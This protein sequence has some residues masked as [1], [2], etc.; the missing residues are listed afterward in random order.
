[1]RKALARVFLAFD[2]CYRLIHRLQP[3]NEFLFINRAVYRGPRREFA[4][5]TTLQPGDPIGIIHFNNRYMSRVQARS[6]NSQSSKRAAFAF[7]AA[8]IRSMQALARQVNQ[9]PALGDLKVISGV[10]W[11]KAHG[12]QLGFEIEPLPPGRRQRFLRA[13]FRLLLTLLFPHLA[14]RENHRLQPHQFWMTRRQLQK[15]TVIEDKH[16]AQRLVKYGEPTV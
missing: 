15:L 14:K 12:E 9:S 7:G 2:S 6:G 4:D 8:L 13:H 3:V 1:M 11:F 5:G 10:T 16:T